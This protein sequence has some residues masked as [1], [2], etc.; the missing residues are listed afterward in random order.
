MLAKNYQ[1]T[2]YCFLLVEYTIKIIDYFSRM[3]KMI[4]NYILV[5]LSKI[6]RMLRIKGV[7]VKK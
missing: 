6:R 7:R 2:N 3:E 1:K 4:I 5:L